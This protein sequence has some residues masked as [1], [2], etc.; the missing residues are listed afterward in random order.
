MR[1]ESCACGLCF[2]QAANDS[3]RK[4]TPCLSQAVRLGPWVKEAAAIGWRGRDSS[5][6]SVC[7]WA[8]PG[9]CSTESKKLSGSHI[10]R[11]QEGLQVNPG[12]TRE[13]CRE[14]LAEVL[15]SPS[16]AP[17]ASSWAH[18]YHNV[19]AVPHGTCTSLSS[20]AARGVHPVLLETSFEG[21]KE[22]WSPSFGTQQLSFLKLICSS[23]SQSCTQEDLLRRST[24]CG[25]E[26]GMLEA[27]LGCSPGPLWCLPVI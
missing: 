5:G 18:R 15:P 19:L 6:Q 7:F 24:G 21:R 26:A 8:L 17:E 2:G 20:V 22:T 13:R 27:P 25:R 16:F 14:T 12:S 23:P 4:N 1:G 9:K 11:T 3:S 10:G